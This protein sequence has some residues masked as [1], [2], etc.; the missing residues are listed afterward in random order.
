MI[1]AL[2]KQHVCYCLL[3][4]NTKFGE[5]VLKIDLILSTKE[6][7]TKNLNQ[8][9]TGLNVLRLVSLVYNHQLFC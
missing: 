8:P 9:L 2:K 3:F 6:H 7:F 1:K 5:R 4:G